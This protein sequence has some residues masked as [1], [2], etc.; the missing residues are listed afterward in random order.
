MRHIQFNYLA[1]IHYSQSVS[2]MLV[3]MLHGTAMCQ[4]LRPRAFARTLARLA[5]PT[6]PATWSTV[7]GRR[8]ASTWRRDIGRL[9]SLAGPQRHMLG[10]ATALLLVSS[11]VSLSVPFGVPLR[12]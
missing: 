4:L 10:K 8:S 5:P 9:A 12:L 7:V 2:A 11:A 1:M 6:R 3:R